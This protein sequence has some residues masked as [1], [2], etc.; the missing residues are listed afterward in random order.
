M[1][2]WLEEEAKMHGYR[3]PPA[4]DGALPSTPPM[5][6][7]FDDEDEGSEEEESDDDDDDGD[8]DDD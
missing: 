2:K 5:S 7:E 4:S 6:P 8:D 1:R 3:G